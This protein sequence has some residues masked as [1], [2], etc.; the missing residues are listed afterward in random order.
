M[1]ILRSHWLSPFVALVTC[2]IF[3]FAATDVAIANTPTDLS[4]PA[5]WHEADVGL[6]AP[7]PLVMLEAPIQVSAAHDAV[8]SPDT[9]EVIAAPIEGGMAKGMLLLLGLMAVVVILAVAL[10]V[11]FFLDLTTDFDLFPNN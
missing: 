4:Q 11:L 5:A 3:L 6:P 2:V 7:V 8:P 9:P 10:G 1:R